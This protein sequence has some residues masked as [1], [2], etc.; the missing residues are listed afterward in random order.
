LAKFA[1]GVSVL[2]NSLAPQPLYVVIHPY[3]WHD[4]FVELGQ[5]ASQKVLLGDVANR[6][7]QDFYVGNWLNLQ[8]FVS[9]N[10]PTSTTNATGAIFNSQSIAFDTR[11]APT[12]E[13]ERDASLRA[14]EL[15]LSAGYAYGV[16]RNAFG[17]KYT[18]DI[19]TP[20]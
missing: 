16:R 9:T 19:T 13:P 4:I 14:W 2:R 10:V 3:Q 11:K 5:P 20:T 6:A 15:N 18:G 1:V 17:V 8:W 7:L 12:L